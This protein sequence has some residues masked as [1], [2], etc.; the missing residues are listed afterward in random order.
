MIPFEDVIEEAFERKRLK[1]PELV[2]EMREQVHTR[3]VKISVRGFVAK[4]MLL[5][6][7]GFRGQSFKEVVWGSW[8]SE[9]VV[10]AEVLTNYLKN[11]NVNE[12]VL[13]EEAWRDV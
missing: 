2:A 9:P 1:Y 11:V 5:L 10:M 6:D 7:F 12:P 13:S 4:S 3:P 8:K